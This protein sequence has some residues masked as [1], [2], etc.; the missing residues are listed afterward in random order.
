MLVQCG[1]TQYHEVLLGAYLKAT[2]VKEVSRIHPGSIYNQANAEIITWQLGGN[3]STIAAVD[4]IEYTEDIELVACS[5]LIPDWSSSISALTRQQ[6]SSSKSGTG[7]NPSA[8]PIIVEVIE[9]PM[10]IET[11]DECCENMQCKGRQVKVTTEGPYC[12][13]VN[14]KGEKLT[15]HKAHFCA[16]KTG[17]VRS[18]GQK[19]K[20]TNST[21]I[22]V[23]SP[24]KNLKEGYK[25]AWNGGA[26][27]DIGEPQRVAWLCKEHRC[28][29]CYHDEGRYVESV[30][31]DL[32][33]APLCG[34]CL[35]HH[36]R[37]C[38]PNT[39]QHMPLTVSALQD[40]GPE[41]TEISYPGW[42]ADIKPITIPLG[43]KAN[44]PGIR[45]SIDDF[46]CRVNEDAEGQASISFFICIC[47][48]KVQQALP[49]ARKPEGGRDKGGRG[50]NSGDTN[51]HGNRGHNTGRGSGG[52]GAGGR[53][54]SSQGGNDKKD[55]LCV[56]YITTSHDG[57]NDG[58]KKQPCD[59][60]HRKYTADEAKQAWVT[61]FLT[62]N[63][64][65][66]DPAKKA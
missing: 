59:Y 20:C 24:D 39:P 51:F 10:S 56:F 8:E 35:R 9:Q 36:R 58:C 31:M 14:L 38:D 1:N 15:Q 41:E 42:K 50:N 4:S 29:Q 53:G 55:K 40:M 13:G 12:L 37:F 19:V 65:T 2:A 27:I 23:F 43:I 7:S 54:N 22:T 30:T 66:L 64:R 46:Q 21:E 32:N 57:K 47:C 63:K 33:S 49:S 60:K 34:P 5:C 17:I 3:G 44:A 6:S 52:R 28:A 16:Y 26:N 18:R 25:Q 61:D 11:T 45:L 48:K 62:R